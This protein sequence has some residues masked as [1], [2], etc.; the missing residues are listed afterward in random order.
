[1]ETILSSAIALAITMF[2]VRRHLKNI[3]A[4]KPSVRPAR[5][6]PAARTEREAA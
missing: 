1:M 4:A 3:P 6:K 5:R 2:F